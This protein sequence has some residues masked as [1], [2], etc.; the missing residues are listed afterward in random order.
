MVENI[1]QI[2]SGITINVYSPKIYCV[3][4]KD[5]IWNSTTCGCVNSKYGYSWLSVYV[6]K[7]LILS[8]PHENEYSICYQ[9]TSHKDF[10]SLR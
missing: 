9:E 8:H 3:C 1:I 6:Q 2:K 7:G 5:Y 4:K 10:R